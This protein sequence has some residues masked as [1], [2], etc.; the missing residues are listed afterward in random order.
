MKKL[1]LAVIAASL[2]G[3]VAVAADAVATVSNVTPAMVK[4]FAAELVELNADLARVNARRAA[5]EPPLAPL[6][7]FT[8]Q[9]MINR[10]WLTRVRGLVTK[11]K[12]AR[13]ERIR[14]ADE[15]FLLDFED[16]TPAKKAAAR[17]A[18]Q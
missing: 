17:A 12:E 5:Q 7:D 13:L 3:S 18:L 11:H 9:T 8:T 14:K 6:P 1:L 2:I 10:L 15:Q 4:S 16:A